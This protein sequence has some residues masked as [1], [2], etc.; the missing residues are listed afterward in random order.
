MTL[1]NP[2]GWPVNSAFS[3][4]K[5]YGFVTE[6]HSTVS[7][8]PDLLAATYPTTSEGIGSLLDELTCLQCRTVLLEWQSQLS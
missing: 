5:L 8:N 7:V 4:Q 1:L 3:N 6:I 2:S